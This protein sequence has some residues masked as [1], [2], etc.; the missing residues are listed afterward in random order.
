MSRYKI[1]T[2]D[3]QYEPGSNGLVL[4][5]KLGITEPID[6]D[7]VESELLLKLYQ[8][9]FIDSNPLSVL[10]FSDVLSWH[11]QWLGNVYD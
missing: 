1:D 10:S 9:L 2:T 7:D 11:R 3:A 6:I 8:K 5:N 4:K